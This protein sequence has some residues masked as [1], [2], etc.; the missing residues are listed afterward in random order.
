[1]LEHYFLKSIWV[2]RT[3]LRRAGTSDVE[4]DAGENC[5]SDWEVRTLD[6]GNVG[7]ERDLG[8]GCI[9]KYPIGRVYMSYLL[10]AV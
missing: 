5:Y 7:A 2:E 6:S 9:S 10:A 4:R 8:V 3:W 1:M